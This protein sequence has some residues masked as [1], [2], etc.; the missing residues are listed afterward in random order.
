MILSHRSLG[1][2]NIS[3]FATGKGRQAWLEIRKDA[4][5][6]LL[7]ARDTL[8]GDIFSLRKKKPQPLHFP[9]IFRAIHHDFAGLVHI[10]G[11]KRMKRKIREENTFSRCGKIGRQ[12]LFFAKSF[13][14]PSSSTISN[15][16][17]DCSQEVFLIS[18]CFFLRGNNF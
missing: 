13:L 1:T 8:K 2:N 6:C 18:H 16:N 11:G 12:N 4:V 17:V 5:C 14:P 3:C 7:S 10:E 15:K 9:F